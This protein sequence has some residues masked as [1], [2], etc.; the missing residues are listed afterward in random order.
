MPTPTPQQR[1]IRLRPSGYERLAVVRGWA[2]RS[3][4]ASALGVHRSSLGRALTGEVTAG[5][6]LVAALM[7]ATQHPK[8]ARGIGFF[9]LFDITTPDTEE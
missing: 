8:R 3:D 4:A 6:A 2:N 9:D 1:T 5:A 7:H